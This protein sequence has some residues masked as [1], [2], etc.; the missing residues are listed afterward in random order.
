MAELHGWNVV[1]ASNNAAAPD[2]WKSGTMVPSEVEPT[3]REMMA[4]MARYDKDNDGSLTTG[5]TSTA[6][7]VTLNSQHSA[8]FTGLRFRAKIGTTNGA[9]PTI[10]PT[11]SAALGAKSIYLPGGSAAPS[12][13]LIAGGVYDFVYDGTNVQAL[14][15]GSFISPLTS[16]GDIIYSSTSTGTAARLALGTQYYVLGAA[17]TAPAWTSLSDAIDNGIGS[18]QGNLLSRTS[19]GWSALSTGTSGQ[20]LKTQGAGANVAWAS[21]SAGGLVPL[22]RKTFS[23]A[24]SV[25]F[26]DNDSAAAFDGTYIGLMLVLEPTT[27]SADD[28]QILMRVSEDGGATPTW[29]SGASDY[30]RTAAGVN[31]GTSDGNAVVTSPSSNGTTSMCLTQTFVAGAGVGNAAGEFVQSVIMTFGLNGASLKKNFNFHT[32]YHMATG[33]PDFAVA[34]GGGSYYGA[35]NAIKGIQLLPS[36]GTFTGAA[37]IYGIKGA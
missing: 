16:A 6:L 26:T 31:S 5:G 33:T 17:S 1:A 25:S 24:S 27:V 37:T 7:T 3:G 35:V 2:G 30:K 21:V 18:T 10:N 9:T 13:S 15:V 23:T 8:W 22:S 32:T 34:A 29:K 4:V 11:G 36:G 12:G 28:T 19:T 14:N 20:Y